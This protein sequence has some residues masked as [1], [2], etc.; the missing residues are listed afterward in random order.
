MKYFFKELTFVLTVGVY[1]SSISRP[2]VDDSIVV[3]Y[4]I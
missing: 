4:I 3:K 2:N 1:Y